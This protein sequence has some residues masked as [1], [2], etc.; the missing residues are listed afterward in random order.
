MIQDHPLGRLL[1]PLLA[2]IVALTPLAIDLYLPAMLV[3]ASD[4]NSDLESVQVS[5]SSYLG[6][7]ALGMMV[8]GP[9]ADRFSRTRLVQVG[10]F[11][12]AISSIALAITREIDVFCALRI[13]QAFFGAAATVVVPGVIRHYYKEQ[14]AKGMSYV[15][16]IMMVA[17][18]IA[19]TVGAA[20]MLVWHWS[21]IFFVL[22]LYASTLLFITLA[23]SIDVPKFTNEKITIHFFTKNY[24]TVFANKAARNDILTS[25]LVSFAFFCFL[26]SVPFIYLDYYN[27]SEQLFGVLFAMNIIALMLGNFLNTRLVP[28]IGSRN[29]LYSGLIIGLLSGIA[30]LAESLADMGVWVIASTIAPLMMSLGII[31]S[32][33]DALILIAFEK[34]TGTATAVIGTLRFGSGALVGPLLALVQ[35][36]STIPFATF[37]FMA[38]VLAGL[39]QMRQR[40]FI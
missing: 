23:T 11:G 37:M 13:L 2:S 19:P 25:M 24:L 22:A 1:L 12:F 38:V 26:T 7:Y 21:A 17:P 8:F 10:L 32:N 31:A 36:N 5:L 28:K 6:G 14:T 4:L 3:I 35:P 39:C 18:L 16:M 27:V 30:V 29:M 20:L 34:H 40:N 33:A 15:S 9:L